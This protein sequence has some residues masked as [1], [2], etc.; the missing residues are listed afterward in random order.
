M[1]SKLGKE[2]PLKEEDIIR[3]EKILKRLRKNADSSEILS[4]NPSYVDEFG[5]VGRVIEILLNNEPKSIKEVIEIGA[6]K[7]RIFH[8]D[9]KKALG[10]LFHLICPY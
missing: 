5:L 10:Y 4:F 1:P 3:L 6:D 8:S 7:Y 9:I 2:I